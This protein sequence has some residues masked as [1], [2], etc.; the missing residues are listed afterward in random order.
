[1]IR[2]SGAATGLSFGLF[3]FEGSLPLR[4]FKLS[5]LTT[6]NKCDKLR[7]CYSPIR[8]FFISS[9][10]LGVTECNSL[11]FSGLELVVRLDPKLLH[12]VIFNFRLLIDNFDLFCYS[13][14]LN[15]FSVERLVF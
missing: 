9:S 2:G 11:G 3:G 7:H 15:L 8:I 13:Y 10:D 1:V 5:D 4:P 14:A 12:S 6:A